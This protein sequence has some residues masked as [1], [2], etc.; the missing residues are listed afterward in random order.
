MKYLIKTAN[1]KTFHEFL[2][3]YNYPLY[4]FQILFDKDEIINYTGKL[5]E[6]NHIKDIKEL[7]TYCENFPN[8]IDK[9]TNIALS[10]LD[11]IDIF[12]H[13]NQ[14]FKCNIDIKYRNQFLKDIKDFLIDN[15]L[16]LFINNINRQYKNGIPIFYTSDA[17]N[18]NDFIK[19]DDKIGDI[20]TSLISPIN[21]SSDRTSPLVIINNNVLL[22]NNNIHHEDLVNSFKAKKYKELTG[23][24]MPKEE[25][26]D[27][28]YDQGYNKIQKY[29][30]NATV[31]V[32]SSFSDHQ[33]A[34][35]EY[36]SG[37]LPDEII[38][39]KSIENSGNVNAIKSTLKNYGF[40]KVYIN[41]NLAWTGK[42]YKR[43]AKLNRLM[44][45]I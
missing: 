28:A 15:A 19:L 20:V 31:G 16:Q 24:D 10:Y 44:K 13:I 14:S 3:E 12:G 37:S 41:N 43:I 5:C 1:I 36:I 30:N 42:S 18:P 9:V 38:E 45:K 8:I 32:G 35:L 29:F 26:L 4:Y 34:L 40:K 7:V 11:N 25:E 2:H 6:N 22:R 21:F 27:I 17:Y 23:K 33:V 39:G